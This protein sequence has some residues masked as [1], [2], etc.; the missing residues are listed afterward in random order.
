VYPF[1]SYCKKIMNVNWIPIPTNPN[2]W[3]LKLGSAKGCQGFP[4][5][6]MFNDE[7]V[8]SAVVNLYI[9]IKIRVATLGTNLSVTDIIRCFSQEAS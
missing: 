1:G 7:R 3:F 6:K 4:E 8:L 9:T 2:H 5:T